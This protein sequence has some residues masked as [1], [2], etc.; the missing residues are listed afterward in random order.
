ME[1]NISTTFMELIKINEDHY[2]I[3]DD[4][5][6][7]E[8]DLCYDP[9]GSPG[10]RGIKYVV[11]CLRTAPDSYWNKFCKKITHSTQPLEYV[12][13]YGEK[14]IDV[15]LYTIEGFDKIQMI[16]LSEVREL[17]GE[18]DVEKWARSQFSSEPNDYE[19][20]YYLG[21]INGYNQAL[22]NNKKKKYTENDVIRIVQKSRETGLKAEYLMLT[23]QPE[24]NWKVKFDQAKLKLV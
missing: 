5:E 17:V 24:T 14:S 10:H 19:E 18:V 4:L 20:T 23:F 11:K 1:K 13:G 21:L 22:E 6:I 16:P 9:E 15:P 3:V 7:K 8:G 2:I 12:S